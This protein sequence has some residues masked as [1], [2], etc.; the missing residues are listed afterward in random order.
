M[1]RRLFSSLLLLTPVAQVKY[2]LSLTWLEH[3]DI[4]LYHPDKMKGTIQVQGTAGGNPT[5]SNSTSSSSASPSTT[6]SPPTPGAEY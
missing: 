4:I 2:H 3:S 5:V 1:Q 6:S